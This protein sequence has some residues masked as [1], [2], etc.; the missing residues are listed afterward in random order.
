MVKLYYCHFQVLLSAT[1]PLTLYD[2]SENPSPG[3]SWGASRC[4]QVSRGAHVNLGE[5]GSLGRRDFYIRDT[6]ESS[7][8]GSEMGTADPCRAQA[9]LEPTANLP[10]FLN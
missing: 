2:V 8:L 3:S 6:P 10:G 9:S 4:F 1:T 5:W 7:Q